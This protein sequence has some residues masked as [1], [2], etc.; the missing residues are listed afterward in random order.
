MMTCLNFSI[1]L[2]LDNFFHFFDLF[3]PFL[4]VFNDCPLVD[5]ELNPLAVWGLNSEPFH[6]KASFRPQAPAVQADPIQFC[7]SPYRILEPKCLRTLFFDRPLLLRC[8]HSWS[9]LKK[10]ILAIFG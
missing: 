9:V 8:L 3:N 6:S 5:F 2:L 7:P 4:P 1:D 10:L